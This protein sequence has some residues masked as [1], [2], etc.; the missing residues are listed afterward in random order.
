MKRAALLSA[1]LVAG[2][3]HGHR[4]ACPE[5]PAGRSSITVREAKFRTTGQIDSATGALF[6]Q[7]FRAGPQGGEPLR[8]VAVTL[9]TDLAIT[10]VNS[11]F[12][13]G[14][15]DGNGEVRWDSVPIGIYALL[16]RR[17]GSEGVSTTVEVR[18]GFT[19]SVTIG[20]RPMP[21]CLPGR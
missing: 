11:Y 1:V 10:D 3:V 6:I 9:H 18:G 17:V 20:L 16:A 19:D 4:A 14:R 5:P 15:T 2:C 12:R 13:G 8:N 21:L 7:V